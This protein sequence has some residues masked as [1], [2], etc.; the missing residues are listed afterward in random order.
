MILILPTLHVVP[1]DA[2]SLHE[3]AENDSD[4]RCTKSLLL[5]AITESIAGQRWCD[6]LEGDIVLGWCGEQWQDLVELANGAGP[7][8]EEDHRNYFGVGIGLCGFCVNVVDVQ[9][10]RKDDLMSL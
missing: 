1:L 8:V 4:T 9:T 10:E 7:T 5:G 3:V 6:D 2:D